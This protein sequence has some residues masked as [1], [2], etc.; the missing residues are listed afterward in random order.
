MIQTSTTTEKEPVRVAILIPSLDHWVAD[1]GLA[2]AGLLRHVERT[3]TSGGER[4]EASVHNVRTS[5]LPQSRATLA[6]FALQNG[7]DWAL[8]LD[9]DMIFPADTLHR[10]LAHGKDLVSTNYPIRTVPRDGKVGPTAVTLDG[11]A[12][13]S[14]D[15]HGIVEAGSTGLAVCLMRVGLLETIDR[16]WFSHD[17]PTEGSSQQVGEDTYFFLKLRAAGHRLFVDRDLSREIGHVTQAPV[18]AGG[19]LSLPRKTVYSAA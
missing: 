11:N 4:I 8:W 17:N 6:E 16:P 10:L 5:V 19:L 18:Y 14:F 2:L 13:L 3:P 9:S 1:F 12:R 7:A 15:G